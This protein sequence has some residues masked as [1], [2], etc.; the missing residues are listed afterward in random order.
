[1]APVYAVQVGLVKIAANELARTVCTVPIVRRFV[2]ARTAT[3]SYAI[4]GPDNVPAKWDG[5][6]KPAPGRVP[7]TH[8]ARIARI[9]AI[10][11]TTRSAH[12]STALA[13]ARPDIAKRIAASCAP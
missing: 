11:R 6:A 8:T 4:H 9:V 5:T 2:N 3:R 7:S 12:P 13:S 1:M 10:A